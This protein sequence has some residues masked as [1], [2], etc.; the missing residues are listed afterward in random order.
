M[1]R[2]SSVEVVGKGKGPLGLSVVCS[3]VAIETELEIAIISGDEAK[4]DND[5]RI[6][7]LLPSK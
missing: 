3:S 5:I 2:N 1:A 6:G 4:F 7:Q